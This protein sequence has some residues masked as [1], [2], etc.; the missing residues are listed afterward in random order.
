M[1]TLPLSC[2]GYSGYNTPTRHLAGSRPLALYLVVLFNARKHIIAQEP[3]L[4]VVLYSIVL[5]LRCISCRNLSS[6]LVDPK[7][8]ILVEQAFR[9]SCLA[10][11][12]VFLSFILYLI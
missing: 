5:L 2:N 10:L 1:L 11:V 7:P 9:S 6:K 12:L 3:S 8:T 4:L